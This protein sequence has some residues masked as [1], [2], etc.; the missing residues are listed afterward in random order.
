MTKSDST[1]AVSMPVEKSDRKQP[2]FCD[3]WKLALGVCVTLLLVSVA[4][5]IHL[6]NELEN[7]DCTPESESFHFKLCVCYI[8]TRTSDFIYKWSVGGAEGRGRD[9][10]DTRP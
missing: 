4:I 6:T 8:N 9:M 2:P 7:T 5:I 10:D 1:T 3:G